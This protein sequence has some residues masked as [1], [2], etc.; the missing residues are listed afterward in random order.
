MRIFI[1][2]FLLTFGVNA[3]AGQINVVTGFGYL[4]DSNQHIIA[5]AQYPQGV[6][7]IPDGITY[8]EVANQSS[9][10]AVQVYEPPINPVET[11]NVDL[12]VQQLFVAFGS[13]V[14]VIPYYSVIKDLAIYKN[15]TGMKA[16]TAALL[17]S[18][19]L[20]QSEIDIL[21]SV[22][23]NQSIVLSNF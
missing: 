9:L 20:T 1:T 6:I 13:D 3:F 21:S 18:G 8:T 10:D 23:S 11:F 5:K 12:F 7:N 19:K 17:A 16:I 15:F 22:L 4:T 2:I 14:N